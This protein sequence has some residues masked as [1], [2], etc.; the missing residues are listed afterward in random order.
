MAWL[1]NYRQAKFRGIS[2]FVPTAESSGGRRG[3]V[4]EFPKKDTPYVEDMGRKVRRFNVEAIIVGDDYMVT[5]NQLINALEKE[6]PGKL[7]HPYLGTLDVFCMDY[8]FRETSREGR[9]VS[10]NM[11]F[12]EA[13]LL[14]FPNEIIDTTGDAALKKTTALQAAKLNYTNRM[15]DLKRRRRPI[16]TQY[17]A[18]VDTVEFGLEVL[19]DAKK[20]VSSSSAY[21]R[22]L[23]NLVDDVRSAIFDDDFL[24]QSILDLMTFGTNEDDEFSADETNAKAQYEEMKQMFELAPTET[25][26]EDDPSLIFTDFYQIN[27]VINAMGLMTIIDYDSVE[28]SQE[29]REVVYAK[30]EEL[31]VATDDDD[32]YV[33]LYNLQTSVTRDLEVRAATLPR[34]A[35]YVPNVSLPAIVIAH[36]LYGNIDEEQDLI[37]RNRIAHPSFV[38][39]GQPIEVRILV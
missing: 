27:A 35:E 3:A 24:S 23:I 17:D 16:A 37:D 1:D 20:T 15:L 22:D 31:M 5:R 9:M 33:A 7:V 30:L 11:V 2:F 21:K 36:E 25:L 12:T 28:E 13:G 39:G 4:Y 14:K 6:G 34:L 10:F 32:L 29:I 19:D 18:M 8:S 38:P 26:T